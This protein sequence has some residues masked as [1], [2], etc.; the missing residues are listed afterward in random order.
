ML[1]HRRSLPV[2]RIV[3]CALETLLAN[4]ANVPPN[5]RALEASAAECWHRSAQRSGS[6]HVV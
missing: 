2:E 6:N 4:A 5:S 3:R 1:L